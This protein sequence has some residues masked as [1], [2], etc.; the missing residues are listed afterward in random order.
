MVP[1]EISRQIVR[2]EMPAALALVRRRGLDADWDET[3]LVLRLPLVQPETGEAFVLRGAMDGY[4]AI[5]PAW[6]FEE[7]RT[8]VVGTMAAFPRPAGGPVSSIYHGKPCICAHFNRLA[9]ADAGGPHAGDWGSATSWL[10]RGTGYTRATTIGDMLAVILEHFAHTRG[11]MAAL[12]P[13]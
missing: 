12:A 13:G 2:V 5:P 8:S 7:P 3:M 1:T 9:Y 11:R 10:Q 4:R 6:D